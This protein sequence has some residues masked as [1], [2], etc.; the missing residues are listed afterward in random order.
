MKA[1]W[2]QQY[3]YC[4][5]VVIKQVELIQVQEARDYHTRTRT[6]ISS[7]L[8]PISTCLICRKT[9]LSTNRHIHY[10]VGLH[11]NGIFIATED[12]QYLVLMSYTPVKSLTNL[13][14]YNGKL[15]SH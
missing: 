3:T 9:G 14:E 2:R 15:Y 13:S 5:P 1:D 8:G 12:D 10:A 7:I 11:I 6:R 4:C